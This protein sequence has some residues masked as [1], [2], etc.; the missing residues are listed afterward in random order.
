MKE[1]LL[2]RLG[3]GVA[4]ITAKLGKIGSQVFTSATSMRQEIESLSVE[5]LE[6]LA[7]RLNLA[8]RS[9]IESLQAMVKEMRDVQE[10]I[11]AR[12]GVLERAAGVNSSLRNKSVAK[13]TAPESRIKP[14]ANA[15]KKR[16]AK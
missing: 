1:R 12:L 3:K 9:E 4:P 11:R 5:R 16:S 13:K 2:G 6:R 8:K 15:G 10:E 7:R 14:R